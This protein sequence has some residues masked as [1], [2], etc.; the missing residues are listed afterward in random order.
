MA[1]IGQPNYDFSK[2][3]REQ[4]DRG[5]VAFREEGKVI[6]SWRTL[7]SDKKGESFNIYRDGTQLNKKSLKKGGTFFIDEQPVTGDATYTAYFVENTVVT[8]TLTL[9][10]NTAEGT[11]SGGGVYVHGT[12]A[13]IQAFP[14][15]GFSFSKWS[16]ENTDNPRL[17]V[18]DSD[19]TL[20]AFFGTGIDENEQ[21]NYIVYP[22][23]AKATIRVLGI[24]ANSEM[25]I[26]NVLGEMVQTVNA[27]PDDDIDVS[28]LA[29]GLYTLRCGNVSLR[30]V[31]T[32]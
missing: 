15:E 12:T 11:V 9:I 14:N 8:H 10:C 30:F 32:R 13:Y 19:M 6:V 3:Q 2:L 18:V 29:D 16:D 5:V 4:L 24:E 27:G 7:T 25:Q 31:K 26:F 20:V 23:P 22:N 28:R 21:A 1:A 17:I